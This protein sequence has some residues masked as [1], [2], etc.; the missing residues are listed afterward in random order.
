MSVKMSFE[1]FKD[2]LKNP[3]AVYKEL[4][5]E[6][7]N[8]PSDKSTVDATPFRRRYPAPPM[9]PEHRRDIHPARQ[10]GVDMC[11]S[12]GSATRGL[13]NP[14]TS[15]AT[16]RGDTVELS[17]GTKVVRT[18]YGRSPAP[19]T[20][21]RVGLFDSSGFN[22]E[23]HQV[24]GVDIKEMLNSPYPEKSLEAMNLILEFIRED[25][26]SISL[27]KD[28][29]AILRKLR[30]TFGV[31]G[32]ETCEPSKEEV[33]KPHADNSEPN[34]Y[35]VDINKLPNSIAEAVMNTGRK[36]YTKPRDGREKRERERNA[37]F[38]LRTPTPPATKTN[39][40][41]CQSKEDE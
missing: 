10:L 25:G 14:Q 15:I 29:E 7:N 22:A 28:P 9:M 39:H 31:G 36:F 20:H 23:F 35:L 3:D 6:K 8:E 11:G 34:L 27:T 5:S 21:Q 16:E 41:A 33:H 38:N 13:R 1:D 18:V 32:E 40:S 4:A 17:D 2:A 12:R 26:N 19:P 37:G 30:E 24:L